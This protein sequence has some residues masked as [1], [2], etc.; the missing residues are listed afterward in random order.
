MFDNG[1]RDAL[2][3]MAGSTRDLQYD[4]QL[5]LDF[6]NRFLGYGNLNSE[7]S[8]IGPE[9]GGGPTAED[10]YARAWV[11]AK[12]GRRE[13]E[14][15]HSYHDDLKRRLCGLSIPAN[16]DWR[17]NIQPTWGPLLNL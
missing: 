5:L 14:D 10:V 9:P 3:P 7:T 11:W 8:L 15:L 6:A 17:R 12:R 13:T 16:F 2:D 1:N 4:E